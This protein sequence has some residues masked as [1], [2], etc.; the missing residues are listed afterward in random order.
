MA[1]ST[2]ERLFF[3]TTLF[4]PK[5]WNYEG[6]LSNPKG[7]RYDGIYDGVLQPINNPDEDAIDETLT[8]KCAKPPKVD[9]DAVKREKQKEEANV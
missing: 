9:V 7:G 3:I 8:W 4:K 2:M 5:Y 1:M 6:N